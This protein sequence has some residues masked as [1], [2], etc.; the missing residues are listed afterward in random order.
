MKRVSFVV[1]FELA[2]VL[3]KVDCVLNELF[4]LTVVKES[5]TAVFESAAEACIRRGV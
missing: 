2:M 4:V 1:R 3:L 5:F